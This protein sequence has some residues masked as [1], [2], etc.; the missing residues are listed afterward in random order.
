[1]TERPILFNGPMVRA[2]LDGRKTQ[3]RRPITIRKGWEPWVYNGRPVLGKILDT[4]HPHRG[5]FGLFIREPFIREEGLYAH[6]VI[7]CPYGQPGDLLWVRETF[8]HISH[9]FDENEQVTD[10]I[11]ERPAIKISGKKFG[12][13]YLT[14]HVIYRADG[15]FEW[16]AGDDACMERCS[17]WRPSIH[18]PRWAARLFLRVKS[19]RIERVQNITEEDALAEGFESRAAFLESWTGIY[20]TAEVWAW[21]VEFER[22]DANP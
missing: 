9:A 12:R 7:P 4:D 8:G 3:T 10:W 6:D 18:M 22:I 1:M 2:I 19:V 11:P 17:H 20:G 13:G 16:N 14:G 21:V 15:G 5:K